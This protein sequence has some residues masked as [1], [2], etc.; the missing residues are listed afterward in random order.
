MKAWGRY[1]IAKVAKVA[2]GFVW[3]DDRKGRCCWRFLLDVESGGSHEKGSGRILM[4]GLGNWRAVADK[5]KSCVVERTRLYLDWLGPGND[6]QNNGLSEKCLTNSCF[7][8]SS[9][10]EF[11]LSWYRWDW[12]GLFTYFNKRLNGNW[13]FRDGWILSMVLTLSHSVQF[14][15]QQ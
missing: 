4:E 8:K 10:T 7:A 15:R 3:R 2:P 1:F 6:V 9:Q 14:Y 5:L 11:Y 13:T 12:K